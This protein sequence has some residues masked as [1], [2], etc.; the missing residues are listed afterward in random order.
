MKYGLGSG[1]LKMRC[2]FYS[3]SCSISYHKNSFLH[4]RGTLQWRAYR[5]FSQKIKLI[6]ENK[7]SPNPTT[8]TKLSPFSLRQRKG[9]IW[10]PFYEER[11][12]PRGNTEP[13][14]SIGCVYSPHAISNHRKGSRFPARP[15]NQPWG[16]EPGTSS[17]TGGRFCPLCHVDALYDSDT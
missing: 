1:R 16:F 6:E 12:I 11:P 8:R 15:L 3:S 5:R 13:S 10:T 9:E 17:F 7:S 4:S 2:T 14:R